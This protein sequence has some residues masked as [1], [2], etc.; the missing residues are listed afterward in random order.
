M[1][2]VKYTVR[3]GDTLSEIA[4]DNFSKYGKALGYKNY[5]DYMNKYLAKV[6]DIDNINNIGVGDVLILSGQSTAKKTSK[7]TTSKKAIVTKG[8]TPQSSNPNILF[9]TWT[10]GK[11]DDTEK[12]ETYWRYTAGDGVTYVKQKGDA[13]V[14]GVKVKYSTCDIPSGATTVLFSVKPISKTKTTKNSKGKE[15]KSNLFKADW[16]DTKKYSVVNK[17]G[18]PSTPSVSIKGK[19]LTAELDNLDT[20]SPNGTHIQFQIVKNNGSSSYKT[21]GNVKIVNKYASFTYTVGSGAEYKVRCRAIRGSL[22]SEWS[23]YSSNVECTVPNAVKEIK[24]LYSKEDGTSVHIDWNHAS[25]AKSY[26]IEYTTKKNYFDYS[27]EN[28]ST[29]TVS[30]SKEGDTP[31]NYYIKTGMESGKEYF[32]RLRS[33]NGEEKTAWTPIKSI[34]LGTKPAAPT[35]WSSTTTVVSPESVNLYWIHNTEDGSSQTEAELEITVGSTTNTYTVKNSTDPDEKDKTSSYEV[36]TDSYTEGTT[37]KWRVR[38]KGLIN[39]WSDWSTRLEIKV[40]AQPT[41][42]LVVSTENSDDGETMEMLNSFPF[43]IRGITGPASQT[44]LDYHVTITSNDSYETT[45]DLGNVKMVKSGDVVYSQY[46]S[47]SNTES[48]ALWAKISADN[49]DL[50][51]D[52]SYTIKCIAAMN[53]GLTVEATHEFTVQWTE[54]GY[55][56]NAE[57]SI[58]KDTLAAVIRPYCDRYEEV[59][60][61][62]AYSVE[63]DEYTVTDTVIDPVNG[64]VVED[65]YTTDGDQVYVTTS[66]D[67][68]DYYYCIVEGSETVLVEDVTLSVYRREFDGTFT[69]LA[70]GLANTWATYILD[71]HPALD[72]A[73]YR[74]VATTI[75]TGAIGFTDLPGHPVGESTIVIQ[76]EEEWT[77]FDVDDG[78][79]EEEHPWS[80]S[81]LKLPYNIDVSENVKPDVEFVEY[82]GRA[83]PVSY[84]GTQIGSSATWNTVIEAN[85]IDTLYALRRL[86]RWMGN[87]YVRE[88]SG[89]GYWANITVSFSQ[90]HGDLTI[91]VTF[92]ITRVEGGA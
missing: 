26:E 17:P 38:T 41:L 62:V 71:P 15:V 78:N 87:A 9:A 25:G 51:N 73:R 31:P 83:H 61:E 34:K 32:F 24:A 22:K 63:N 70:T 57:I 84:Y 47:S 43:Y 65:T 82:I 64:D 89:T 88:P 68:S 39:S 13:T 79:A 92:N 35:T 28:V 33:V 77:E 2:V 81:M 80:G 19:T 27:P 8:P 58:D 72:Y 53:S 7:N 54:V 37:I 52:A 12:Y 44:P 1:A 18:V 11:H 50:E 45:D 36:K 75:S 90:K 29:I 23:T 86:Q 46:I 3:S 30:P 49:V 91:P 74:I 48:G 21:S 16:S 60:H 14:N 40:Y 59:Y 10:W 5:K 6:N 76:W 69:E 66:S 85:D 4:Y 42:E 67:G 20:A 56:P 55:E